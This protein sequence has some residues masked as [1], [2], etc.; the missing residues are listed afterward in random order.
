MLGCNWCQA[1][2]LQPN[3]PQCH[4]CQHRM[5]PRWHCH[6]ISHNLARLQ[7]HISRPYSCQESPLGGKSHLTPP[8][9]ELPLWLV[10]PLKTM[11]G[12]RPE[13]GVMEAGQLVTLGVHKGQHQMFPQLPPQK[14]LCLNEAAVQR[15][16]AMTLHCWR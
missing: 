10:K 16:R 2:G 6:S 5:P 12:R 9:T 11:G 13:D 8:L 1:H 4:L 7:P 14:S 3:R 15:P